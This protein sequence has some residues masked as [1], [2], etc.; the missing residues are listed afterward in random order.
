M[1]A[2]GWYMHAM[3]E[4]DHCGVWWYKSISLKKTLDFSNVFRP[5][6]TP[7]LHSGQF[8]TPLPLREASVT[9][10]SWPVSMQE[11]TLLVLTAGIATLCV[12]TLCTVWR[13]NALPRMFKYAYYAEGSR[14]RWAFGAMSP[15]HHQLL[16]LPQYDDKVVSLSDHLLR[17]PTLRLPQIKNGGRREDV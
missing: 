1:H 10:N 11:G 8:L 13:S 17:I 16:R 5:T 2:G 3:F 7:P 12:I 9:V 15:K 4:E 6:H 14:T